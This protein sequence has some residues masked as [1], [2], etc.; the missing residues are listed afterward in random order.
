MSKSAQLVMAAWGAVIACIAIAFWINE[1]ES[2]KVEPEVGVMEAV[3]SAEEAQLSQ[4]EPEEQYGTGI[5][6]KQ[7]MTGRIIVGVITLVDRY[8]Q[9]RNMA[10][11]EQ[12]IQPLLDSHWPEDRLCGAIL[13]ARAG[14]YEPAQDA[15]ESAIDAVEGQDPKRVEEVAALAK[16]V[17][18][19]IGVLE[20]EGDHR[21]L[22]PHQQELLRRRLGWIGDLLI[23]TVHPNAE[24]D[25]ELRDSLMR[26]AI[27]GSIFML[28]G[29]VGGLVGFIWLVL[30]VAK[31][32]KGSLALPL[33]GRSKL[34]ENLILVFALWFVLQIGASLVGNLILARSARMEGGIGIVLQFALMFLPLIALGLPLLRGF[35]WREI[36]SE[37][38]LHRGRGVMREAFHGVITYATALPLLVGGVIL[39]MILAL[40]VGGR[41]EEASHPIQ[42]AV[43]EGDAW[44][45]IVLLILAAVA[46]PIIEEI[47]FRGVL[48]RHLRDMTGAMGSFLS[49][50]LSA[51]GSSLIFAAI[52][53]QGL[54][55]VPI[56]GALAVAF[57][58]ARETRGSLISQM[59]AHGINNGLIIG[60]TISMA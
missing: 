1:S 29:L 36:C 32:A 16:V 21:P 39:A 26:M 55:F 35:T 4:D 48:Y 24:F 47:V 45:R 30:L 31:S 6:F 25:A 11:V 7:V 56:L 10:A 13:L 41:I 54:L 19:A 27:A 38:G 8:G 50:G 59:V 23:S 52:H 37:V 42:G 22:E 33:K 57:C 14:L 3:E 18:H 51:I 60:L 53:P 44:D 5:G 15:V 17:A 34:A 20:S 40:V 2:T 49:F 9:G 43:V 46:A 12:N 28:I 58:I